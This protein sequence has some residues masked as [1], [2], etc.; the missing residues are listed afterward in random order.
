MVPGYA[1]GGVLTVEDLVATGQAL[2]NAAG[3]F[4]FEGVVGSLGANAVT[5]R[6]VVLVTIRE[7]MHQVTTSLATF[8]MLT[9]LQSFAYHRLGSW[10]CWCSP[11]SPS[12]Q[13]IAVLTLETL[14]ISPSKV[15]LATATSPAVPW[16]SPLM[17][18][19]SK[20]DPDVLY[21]TDG[22]GTITPTLPA[23]PSRTPISL[24]LRRLA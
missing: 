23:A 24:P 6:P 11:A 2:A 13:T 22:D 19:S 21:D 5:L 10:K 7:Q 12:T 14:A 16:W 20:M 18:C 15:V 3:T 4:T 8:L 9:T 17:V 1:A